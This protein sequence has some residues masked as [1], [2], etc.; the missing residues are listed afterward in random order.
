MTLTLL[1]LRVS[2][3]VTNL[4]V[5]ADTHV[6]LYLLIRNNVYARSIN[7]DVILILMIRRF[8]VVR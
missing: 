8:Y 3:T 4:D 6:V 1:L 5:D 2:L 7:V